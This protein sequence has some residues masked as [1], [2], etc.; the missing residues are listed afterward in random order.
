MMGTSLLSV[1]WA[2]KQSGLI[3]GLLIGIVMAMIAG[4]TGILVVKIHAKY[5]KKII[6]I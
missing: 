6:F 5:G 3:A 1:P 2:V 4:Y